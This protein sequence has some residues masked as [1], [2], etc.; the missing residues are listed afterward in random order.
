MV[1]EEAQP[2]RLRR[3]AR[4]PNRVSDE[5]S[6]FNEGGGEISLTRTLTLT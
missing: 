1:G 3:A 5:I 4:V 2:L 6:V